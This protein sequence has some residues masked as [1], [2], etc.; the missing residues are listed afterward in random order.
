MI[1]HMATC[2]LEATVEHQT[3]MMLLGQE[4]KILQKRISFLRGNSKA[5]F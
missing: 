1:V 5:C 2:G 4:E 3:Q